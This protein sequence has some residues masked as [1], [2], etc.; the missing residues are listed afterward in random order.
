MD[1]MDVTRKQLRKYLLPETVD[2]EDP[3]AD[4]DVFPRSKVMRF[5]LSARNRKVLML[6]GSVLAVV[7]SRV[8][9]ANRLG[10]VADVARTFL[11]R[12]R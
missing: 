5:A 2:P 9:G 7:A 11:R 4:P 8:I 1:S 10:M 6:S 3:E 12:N